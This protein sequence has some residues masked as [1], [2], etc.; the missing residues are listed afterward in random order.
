MKY[1]IIRKWK[2]GKYDSQT[3]QKSGQEKNAKE[4]DKR[5]NRA[6]KNEI[7]FSR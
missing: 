5:K 6:V 1:I 3:K 4:K 2:G 7:E